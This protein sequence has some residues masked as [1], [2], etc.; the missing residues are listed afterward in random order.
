VEEQK[1]PIQN[2]TITKKISKK[3]KKEDKKG[4]EGVQYFFI[5]GDK[6]DRNG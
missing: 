3:G 5:K 4:G 2:E 6:Q 1:P